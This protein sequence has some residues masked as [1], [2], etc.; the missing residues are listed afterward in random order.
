MFVTRDLPTCKMLIRKHAYIFMKSAAESHNVILHSIVGSDSLFTST[1]EKCI[2]CPPI[3]DNWFFF[4]M[5]CMD[6]IY[7][8]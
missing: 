4:P 5:T 8:Q 7:P 3:L 2:V 6:V 1:L